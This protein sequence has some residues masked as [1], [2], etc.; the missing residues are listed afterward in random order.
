[1][2]SSSLSARQERKCASMRVLERL[3]LVSDKG[4]SFQGR[5]GSVVCVMG[6]WH[7]QT[8]MLSSVRG[9]DGRVLRCAIWPAA[10][11]SDLH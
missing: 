10:K 1:M 2:A 11:I 5:S 4:F 3:E 8:L 7:W 9:A 6:D